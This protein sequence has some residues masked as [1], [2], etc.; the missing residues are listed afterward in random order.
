MRRR[1]AKTLIRAISEPD[2]AGR[3][4]VAG[5]TL[6]VTS[7]QSIN[8]WLD[9]GAGGVIEGAGTLTVGGSVSIRGIYPGGGTYPAGTSISDSAFT[10]SPKAPSLQPGN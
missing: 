6:R 1:S 9:L 4:A 2:F 5:G 10:I 3:F 7:N 8:A